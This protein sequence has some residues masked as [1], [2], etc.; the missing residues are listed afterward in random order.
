MQQ[1]KVMEQA[2]ELRNEG[3]GVLLRGSVWDSGNSIDIQH[4][5]NA[6]VQSPGCRGLER[7]ISSQHDEVRRVA[8]DLVMRAVLNSQKNLKRQGA[9]PNELSEHIARRSRELSSDAQI[10]ARKFGI[11]DEAAIRENVVDEEVVFTASRN[12]VKKLSR[13]NAK[14]IERQPSTDNVWRKCSHSKTTRAPRR[15]RRRVSK[16]EIKP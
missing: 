10:L 14:K 5:L 7:Y 16:D 2:R 3:Y 15:A 6:F 4:N 1:E 11:A 13:G 12:L 9:S 8:K